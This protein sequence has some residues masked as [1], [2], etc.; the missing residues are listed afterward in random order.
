MAVIIIIISVD[1]QSGRSNTQTKLLNI[2]VIVISFAFRISCLIIVVTGYNPYN[3]QQ[4]ILQALNLQT[5]VM[6]GR[7]EKANTSRKFSCKKRSKINAYKIQKEKKHNKDT[8][9]IS[10]ISIIFSLSN[11]TTAIISN[12][13]ML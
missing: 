1:V 12:K 5:L 7:V 4:T 2:K 6:S 8:V 13:L 9:L 3:T 10:N 11:I